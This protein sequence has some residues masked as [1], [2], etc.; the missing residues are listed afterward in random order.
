M[1]MTILILTLSL[2]I[3]IHIY[4]IRYSRTVQR[5]E[6]PKPKA[7]LQPVIKPKPDDKTLCPAINPSPILNPKP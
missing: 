2:S 3:Y 5:S 4:I 1:M 7:G 6:A